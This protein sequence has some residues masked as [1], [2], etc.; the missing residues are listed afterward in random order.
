M[1]DRYKEKL[2][3]LSENDLKEIHQSVSYLQRNIGQSDFGLQ[4]SLHVETLLNKSLL[5]HNDVVEILS[6]FLPFVSLEDA[7]RVNENLDRDVIKNA[8]LNALNDLNFD[9]L[10]DTTKNNIL[11]KVKN[12]DVFVPIEQLFMTGNAISND[13]VD[14]I[15]Q[16]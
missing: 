16:E 15:I 6:E 7:L 5:K 10:D 2:E 1:E 8:N 11:S 3:D 4:F 13:L 14:K 12:K 9:E